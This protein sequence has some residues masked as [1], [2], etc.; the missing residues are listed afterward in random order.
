MTGRLSIGGRS[1]TPASFESRQTRP[2]NLHALS[3]PH[4]I[5]L[6][7]YGKR[8]VKCFRTLTFELSGKEPNMAYAFEGS[9]RDGQ[10]DFQY[11]EYIP[12]EKA[13]EDEEEETA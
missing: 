4:G 5:R 10:M 8:W 13:D 11:V 1:G 3:R 7:Q 6:I 9:I 2:T 12:D